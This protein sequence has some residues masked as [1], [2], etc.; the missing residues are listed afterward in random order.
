[1][2][3]RIL[4]ID[5]GYERLG[6]AILEGRPGNE[7]L[8]F[9]ECFR[10]SAQQQHGA[11]LAAIAEQL[12]QIITDYAPESLAIETLFFNVNQKTAIKV[13]ESRGVILAEAGRAGLPIHEY[14][15]QQ[16]KI[17]TT[18]QGNSSKQQVTD[19]TTRLVTINKQ[20]AH[21]DEYDAIAVGITAIASELS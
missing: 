3:K 6:I 5:P 13:A 7:T 10:T 8:L 14:S 1:M 21:D 4:S 15:P 19:M 11:R 16:I 20:I 12:T 17:A 18:G 2:S 9:S